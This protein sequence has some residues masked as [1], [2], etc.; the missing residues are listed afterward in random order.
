MAGNNKSITK[1]GKSMA[2]M[3]R[4]RRSTL[5][6]PGSSLKMIE[7]ARTLSVDAIFL[8]LEDAVAPLAK[9]DAR[10]TVVTELIAGGFGDRIKTVRINAR[11]TE[12]AKDDISEIMRGAGNYL[13]CIMLPK[14]NTVQDVKW[15]DKQLSKLEKEIGKPIGSTGIEIQIEDAL[16]LINIEQIAASSPR[17]ET[18]VLGPGDLMANLNMR[19]LVV[20]QQPE[21][22]VEGDAYHYIMMKLLVAARAYGKQIIDGPYFQIKDLTGL[23]LTSRRSAALGFDGKWVVHPDQIDIVNEI[24]SPRQDDY[25]KA[26]LILEAYEFYTSESGGKL[27][28]IMFGG[29]MIDEASRKMSQVIANK[30]RAAGLNRTKTFSEGM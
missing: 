21:G 18:I 11:S 26:E 16:G 7:K 5:A 27:G 17:I 12:W 25:D 30:G 2:V 4:I 8:D 3:P 29:E 9:P 23:E 19:T 24:F 15:L 10:Q 14:V 6:V 20:G 1:T 28:A 22:Y 13:D